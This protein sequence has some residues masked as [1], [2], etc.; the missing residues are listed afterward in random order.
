[1]KRDR[2]YLTAS[3]YRAELDSPLAPR[4][5]R[6]VPEV[7]DGIRFDSKAEARRY[8]ELKLIERSGLIQRLSLQPRFRFA[9]GATY[10]GDFAYLEGAYPDIKG[11]W[12]VEDV[13]G[14]ETAV[15]R[16]KA[17]LMAHEYP[18][19]EL[20]IVKSSQGGNRRGG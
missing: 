9:C 1:M 19:W 20:R 6:N 5:Y 12:V 14:V 17:C 18:D 11:R 10:V 7:V 8:C 16:L 3:E 15:F 4:K 13:K 2:S